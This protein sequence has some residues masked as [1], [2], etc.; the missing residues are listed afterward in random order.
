MTKKHHIK[1]DDPE[2][3]LELNVQVYMEEEK[4][5]MNGLK[6]SVRMKPITGKRSD[7]LK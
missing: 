5:R 3:A 6:Y 1:H 7:E 4:K 2:K